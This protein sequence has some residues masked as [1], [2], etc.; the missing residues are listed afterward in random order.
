MENKKKPVSVK[1]KLDIEDIEF[2]DARCGIF[3][4]YGLLD[5]YNEN[6]AFHR[7]PFDVAEKTSPAV[8]NLNC[9]TSGGRIRFRTDSEYVA[10]NME[11]LSEWKGS[12][13]NMNVIGAS[14]F[15]IYTY[16]DEKPIY[17]G[18][19]NPGSVHGK[20]FEAVVKFET[21]KE[22]ELL[23]NFPLY[24]SCEKLY[25]GLKKNATLTNGAKY[26]HE[27]PI[28]YYGS[29][30]TQG[31]CASRP[32]NSYPGM[33][34]RYFD[35]DFVNLGFSGACKA[36]DAMIEYIPTLD[37]S[38]FVYDYDANAPTNEH[39][40]ETHEKLFKAFRKVQP[41]TP[42]IIMS[43]THIPLTPNAVKTRKIRHD[44]IYGTYLNAKNSGDNN[45]YFV[46]GQEIFK[47]CGY[48]ACTCDTI[49]PNDL[50]FYCM[51]EAVKKVIEENSLL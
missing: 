35:T 27:R 6:E 30:I 31:G 45:V 42:V 10:I 9:N 47:I 25:I 50:G 40:A 29:S 23:I 20:G 7:I 46:D 5:A 41:S 4:I 19:Y 32:G 1:T 17:F 16:I 2:Y 36:E 15:D 21:R 3:D 12:V 22:R 34:S 14:G 26:K 18:S 38:I 37:M 48:D 39:L 24:D 13:G 33:L 49:H 43:G 11:F 28:V 51:S 8:K 44:I